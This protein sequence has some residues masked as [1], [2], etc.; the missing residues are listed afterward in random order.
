M[1]SGPVRIL[2]ARDTPVP[3]RGTTCIPGASATRDHTLPLVLDRRAA[4]DTHLVARVICRGGWQG[5]A[6]SWFPR[7]GEERGHVRA[8]R[9]GADELRVGSRET[10]GVLAGARLLAPQ[11]G[12]VRHAAAA[13]DGGDGVDVGLVGRLVSSSPSSIVRSLNSNA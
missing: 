7:P 13:E 4:V 11:T 12:S 3:T 6:G 2:A 1:L 8:G 9:V 10:R 5:Y